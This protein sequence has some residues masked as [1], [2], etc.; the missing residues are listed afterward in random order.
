[1]NYE[2][3]YFAYDAI[4]VQWHDADGITVDDDGAATF[5]WDKVNIVRIDNPAWA[6]F[7]GTDEFYEIP[8]T[9]ARPIKQTYYMGQ[10]KVVLMKPRDE[11]KK[12]MWS[13]DNAPWTLG[14]P[15]TTMLKNVDD[16]HG[17]WRKPRYVDTMD[18][19]DANL[20][21]PT[22]DAEARDYITNYGDVSV[23]FYNKLART[24]S[25]DGIVGN[26]DS[27]DGI[28]G[29]QTNLYFDHVASVPIGRCPSDK[30]CGL[31]RITNI[32]ED[33]S[34][35]I[36]S[37]DAMNGNVGDSRKTSTDKMTETTQQNADCGGDGVS[38][39][40]DSFSFE[41]VYAKNDAVKAQVDALNEQIAELETQ[42]SEAEDAKAVAQERADDL[43]TKVDAHESEQKE[44]IVA[45]IVE[46]TD[47][48][49]TA[50]ELMALELTDVEAKFALVEELTS[51]EKVVDTGVDDEEEQVSTLVPRT[52]KAG[53]QH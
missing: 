10:D 47:A 17:F 1:M 32:S 28:D 37:S 20:M 45:K 53:E 49:G 4:P 18:N 34:S 41:Y 36:V 29:Y 11:L 50:E 39:G 46:R 40:V 26:G 42:V 43:Q 14:H 5:D 31:D 35:Q 3:T 8:A 25:Y 22:N 21:V 44:K 52:K 51:T 2:D 24:D 16:V 6:E 38:I 30:G 23:G 15:D 7:F 19:L 9:V 13:L 27:T 33:S 48:L 12:A